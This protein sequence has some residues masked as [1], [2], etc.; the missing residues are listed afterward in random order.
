MIYNSG[1]ARLAIGTLDQALVVG[2][3]GL[4]EWQTLS[5]APSGPA[6]GDLDG[7]YPNPTI[8]LNAVVT[9]RINNSAVTTDKIGNDQ[10]TTAKIADDQI[11]TAKVLNNQITYA[12]LQNVASNNRIL[13]NDNGAGQDVQE[14]TAAEVRTMINVEDG[15]NNYSHPNHS[16]DVT[17]V[18]DGATTIANNVVTYAKLQNISANNVLLG[19]DNGTNQDVQELT[20]S[21]V[22]TLLNV[23]SNDDFV[24]NDGNTASYTEIRMTILE[25]GDWNM[26]STGILNV[27]HGLTL[28]DIRSVSVLIRDDADVDHKDFASAL[29]NNNIEVDG[30]NIQ[31][32]R[33]SAGE[34]DNTSYDS[35][36]FNRGW[37]TMVH[38]A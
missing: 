36:S 18:G 24:Q 37:I 3:S 33:D 2:A 31:L 25:L 29:G 19:N 20:A 14:L 8:A 32:I 23:G 22:R 13:G 4:P 15:A 28:G 7:T 9:D 16:G 35:T 38:E 1:N 30:T 10:V 6:G 11:T 34:F 21:E 12:K 5:F 27:A 26:D 17:S